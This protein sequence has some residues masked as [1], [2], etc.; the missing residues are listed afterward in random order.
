VYAVLSGSRPPYEQAEVEDT[1]DYDD[2]ASETSSMTAS[3]V[4]ED[5]SRSELQFRLMEIID[6]VDNLYKLSIRIRIPTLDNR[7]TKAATFRQ[8]DKDTKVDL[9]SQFVAYDKQHTI[10]T[11]RSL[12]GDRQDL[13]DGE[14]EKD[15][16]AIRLSGAIT[17]R[18]QQ[19]KYW[20]KHRAKLAASERTEGDRGKATAALAD[21]CLKQKYDAPV[22][23]KISDYL[24]MI[25]SSN[26]LRFYFLFPL[27]CQNSAD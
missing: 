17:R 24:G 8:I 12:R 3:T 11:L 18:R 21:Y 7:A 1:D 15:P 6:I 14:L 20:K 4:E 5:E 9:I 22:Y 26:I 13:A 23:E 19:F 10:E 2:S 16:L 27:T 25:Y